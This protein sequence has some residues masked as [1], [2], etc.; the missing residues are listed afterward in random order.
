MIV[1]C[2]HCGETNAYTDEKRG[3]EVLCKG[4]QKAFFVSYEGVA[5]K[6]KESLNEKAEKKAKKTN[7]AN[8]QRFIGVLSGAGIIWSY[9]WAGFLGISVYYQITHSPELLRELGYELHQLSYDAF[10]EGGKFIFHLVGLIA[11]LVYIFSILIKKVRCAFISLCICVIYCLVLNIGDIA[12][13][14]PEERRRGLTAGLWAFKIGIH[15]LKYAL[16]MLLLIQGYFGLLKL[17]KV[18]IA[19][20]NNK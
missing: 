8:V 1:K 19:S 17:E 20:Q 18:K 6:N 7:R 15:G 12:N 3:K 13:L 5:A 11:T 16:E 10:G 9:V 4:C 2:P 14:S